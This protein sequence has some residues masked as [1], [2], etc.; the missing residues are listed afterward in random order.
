[1]LPL[2]GISK[3]PSGKHHRFHI[4]RLSPESYSPRPMRA[5]DE[6]L[7]LPVG[8][9]DTPVN[10]FARVSSSPR[11]FHTT[12]YTE[13]CSLYPFRD[14]HISLVAAGVLDSSKN[15]ALKNPVGG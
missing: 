15:S 9:G 6:A 14:I 11:V 2:Q 13:G 10:L 1:M 8:A 12:D 3:T 4:N 7:K 5:R